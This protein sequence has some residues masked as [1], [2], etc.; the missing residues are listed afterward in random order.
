[1]ATVRRDLPVPADRIWRVLADGRR[2]AAWVVG[3]KRVRRVEPSWPEVGST[4]H[5]TVGV[6]PLHIDDNT[7]VLE[8]D[9]GT[10]LLLEARIRPLGRARVELTL[11]PTD[12]GT[13]VVMTEVPCSPAPVRRAGVIFEPLIHLRNTEALRRLESVVLEQPLP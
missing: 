4:F 1:M 5:H 9:P 6:W 8:A 3:A 13:Q 7:A 12:R 11:R 2:Y 10:R